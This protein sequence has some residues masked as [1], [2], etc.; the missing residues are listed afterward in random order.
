MKRKRRKFST[1]FKLKVVLAAL[2]ERETIGELAQ[3]FEVHPNQI[4]RWKANF[5]DNTSTYMSSKDGIKVKEATV[6]LDE[7]YTKIGKLQMEID[8]LK[9]KLL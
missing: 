1:E 3:K 2:K 9:K 4:S 8:F 7:L 5:L 6:D